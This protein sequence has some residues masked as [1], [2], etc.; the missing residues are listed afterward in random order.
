MENIL[1]LVCLSPSSPGQAGMPVL[2]SLLQSTDISNER[3]DFLFRQFLRIRRHL[4]FAI[5]D[6][7]KNAFIAHPVLPFHVAEFARVV[8][9]SLQSFGAAVPSVTGGTVSRI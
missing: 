5:N 1:P 3:V 6:G 9:A 2:L 7:V 4:A 8:D